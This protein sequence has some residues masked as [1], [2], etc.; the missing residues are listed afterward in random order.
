[1]AS[2][3]SFAS[4]STRTISSCRRSSIRGTSVGI[5]RTGSITGRAAS[6]IRYPP[7][8]APRG[9]QS[10]RLPPRAVA[11]PPRAG[12]VPQNRYPP[13][14]SDEQVAGK[15]AVE[16]QSCCRNRPRSS[17][18]VDV[19]D[20]RVVHD[21]AVDDREH[22]FQPLDPLVRHAPRIQEVV[23]EDHDVRILAHLYRAELV[24]LLGEPAVLRGV[25][26]QG[27]LP[28]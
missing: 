14:P 9:R 11:R 15:P 24:L 5:R 18:V 6:A 20:F 12:A 19:Q 8:R 4:R 27:F 16:K 23:A 22:R 17:A 1:M 3:P 2:G 7:H 10:G 21:L 25:E 28:G 26:A 13:T